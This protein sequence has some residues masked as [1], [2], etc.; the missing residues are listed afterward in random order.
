MDRL[1]PYSAGC[2]AVKEALLKTRERVLAVLN[3]EPVDRLPVDLWY[4]DEIG[5]LLRE[6]YGAMDD[7]D[8]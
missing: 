3:R 4:T 5:R 8:L 2:R 7:L 1:P 6:H